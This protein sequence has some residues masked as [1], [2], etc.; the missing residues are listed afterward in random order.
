MALRLWVLLWVLLAHAGHALSIHGSTTAYGHIFEN[1]IIQLEE[2]T[3]LSLSIVASGSGRGVKALMSGEAD[4]AMVSGSLT[5]ALAAL[6][7][8]DREQEFYAVF[9]DNAYLSV[10][11]HPDNQV[12]KLTKDQLVQVLTGDI[13]HWSE[14]GGE[15]VPIQVVIEVKG[16]GDRARIEEEL[17]HGQAITAAKLQALPTSQQV[18]EFGQ[19]FPQALVISPLSMLQKHSFKVM[20][21]TVSIPHPLFFVTKGLPT[22]NQ[23]KLIDAAIKKLAH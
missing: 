2:E 5:G 9:I 11:I 15:D 6:G 7:I 23:R 12:N 1:H 17:L 21:D 4:M 22:P 8:S 16:G 14:L 20:E 10:G 18:V 19:H 3:G 13:T